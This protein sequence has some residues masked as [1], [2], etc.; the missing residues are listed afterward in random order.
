MT[1]HVLSSNR[2]PWIDI[3]RDDLVANRMDACSTKVAVTLP[4]LR[5]WIEKFGLDRKKYLRKYGD[6]LVL[7]MLLSVILRK[8]EQKDS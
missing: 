3:S 6:I 7:I 5:Y 2:K 4:L 1:C 8:I